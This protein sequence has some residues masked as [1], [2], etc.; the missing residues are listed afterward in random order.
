MI[1]VGNCKWVDDSMIIRVEAL[2]TAIIMQQSQVYEH[3]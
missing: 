2:I 3:L 1:D